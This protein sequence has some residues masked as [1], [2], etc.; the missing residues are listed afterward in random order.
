MMRIHGYCFSLFSKQADVKMLLDAKLVDVA[1]IKD[2]AKPVLQSQK[3]AA[4]MDNSMLSFDK[5]E[6]VMPCFF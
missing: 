2:E 1:L 4:G 6:K 3:S 5:D